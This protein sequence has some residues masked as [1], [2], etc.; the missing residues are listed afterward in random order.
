[1]GPSAVSQQALAS[2]AVGGFDAHR[3]VHRKATAMRPLSHR[4]RV[5][6]RKQTALH[7]AA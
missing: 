3:A 4:P 7:E 5:I 1:V 6:A 2:G